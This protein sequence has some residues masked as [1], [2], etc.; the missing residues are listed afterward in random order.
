MLFVK[1]TSRQ[2]MVTFRLECLV[3][4]FLKMKEG[5]LSLLG[6][7]L[8]VFV[9]NTKIS[10]FKLTLNF[11]NLVFTIMSLIASQYLNTVLMRWVRTLTSVIFVI[12][13]QYLDDLHESVNQYF[14][15]DQCIMLQNHSWVKGIFKLQDRPIDCNVT[16]RTVHYTVSGF[17]LQLNSKKLL[18]VE[19]YV[20]S[21][22]NI[23]DY[24]KGLI[25]YSSIF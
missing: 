7:Q 21:K 8:K 13:C 23:H 9:D 5:S 22:K 17:T 4:I 15:K 12:L 6:K 24:L 2:I 16:V 20:I 10:D 14:L 25:K 1:T 18:L 19:V 3:D 11:G